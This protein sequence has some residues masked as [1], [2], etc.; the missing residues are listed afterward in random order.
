MHK[1]LHFQYDQLN[2]VHTSR[3][4]KALKEKRARQGDGAITAEDIG[5]IARQRKEHVK[6]TLNHFRS[7]ATRLARAK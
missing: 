4:F 6:S 7:V 2:R 3:E 5:R 1:M